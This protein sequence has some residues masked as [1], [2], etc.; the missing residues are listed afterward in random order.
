MPV[1]LELG[2]LSFPSSV[3]LTLVAVFVGAWLGCW[4]A[5]RLQTAPVEPLFWRIVFWALVVSRGAYVLL[6]RDAYLVDPWTML[7]VRDGGFEP[8]SGLAAVWVLT[9]WYVLRGKV[10]GR[11]LMGAMTAMTAVGVAGL[12]ALQMPAGGGQPLPGLQMR[13]LDGQAV[14][15]QAF[16]GR[17]VIVNLWATWC[18]HCVREMPVLAEAQRQHPELAVVFVDQGEEVLRVRRF[19]ESRGLAQLQNVLM[20]PQREAGQHFGVRALPTTLFFG[21][22]GQL[23][24][25]RIGAVSKATLQARVERLLE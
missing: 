7:D 15:L 5:R 4:L 11:P 17:P 13:T 25:I 1:S 16:A 21:R 10:A 20:D 19:L 6:Y 14:S 23:Q 3:L 9:L 2:P 24:E 22:D 12:M 8:W 18:P